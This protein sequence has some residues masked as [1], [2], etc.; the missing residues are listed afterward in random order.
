MLPFIFLAAIFLASSAPA[1]AHWV[2]VGPPGGDARA[3]GFDP[4]RPNV[5]YAGTSDGVLYRS[6][7]GSETWRRLDPGFPKRGYSLDEIAVDERGRILIAYWEVAGRDGGV[8]RSED[9]GQTFTLL[10]GIA[11]ESVRA[12]AVSPTHPDVV[13]AGSLTGVFRSLDG[14]DTW[15]RISP[16]GHPELRNVE[17]VAIDSR[18]AGVLYAGTWH[19]AWKTVDAGKTWRPIATGMIADSDVFTLNL[20]RRNED[21][22]YGTACSGIYRSGNAGGQWAKIHGIPSSSRRTRAFVQHPAHPEVF[23]AGTTEGLWRSNDDLKTWQLVTEKELV[24]NSIAVLPGGTILAGTDGGGI[25]R[26]RDGGDSWTGANEG[27]SEHLVSRVLFDAPADRV[28]VAVREDR[29]Q[30]GV[31]AAS[32]SGGA[33]TRLAE[34]LEGREVFSLALQ[35]RALLAGTDDGVFRLRETN[36]QWRRLPMASRGIELHPRIDDLTTRGAS[37]VFAASPRGLLRSDDRGESWELVD[38]GLAGAVDAVTVTE[39]GVVYAATR[40]HLYRS[41]DGHAFARVSSLPATVHRLLPAGERLLVATSD[42]LYEASDGGRLWLLCRTLPESTIAALESADG[43][44]TL[45]ASDFDRGGV[46]RSDDAGKTWR[47]LGTDGL[48]SPRL[49]T[50][51]LDPRHPERILAAAVTGGLHRYEPA[52]AGDAAATQ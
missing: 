21:V 39:A 52:S 33:W 34:G 13:V 1:A 11:G 12:L 25:R 22:L 5:V 24:V 15:Q 26:T 14:G 50:L 49:W 19:L 30:G 29:R 44:R 27:F 46:Y 36:D 8:A 10:P 45:I 42:G 9:G 23:F 17:S 48:R 41:D 18:D 16:E 38:L 3:L 6:D 37:T 31:F 28:L 43:G 20:D 7:D 32:P 35:G 2:P 4:R 51:A 47:P 40:L